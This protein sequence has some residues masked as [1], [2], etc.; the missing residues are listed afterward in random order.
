LLRHQAKRTTLALSQDLEDAGE[1]DRRPF[2]PDVLRTL[3]GDQ[4]RLRAAHVGTKQ[5]GFK[6]RLS[7]R[8]VRLFGGSCCASVSGCVLYRGARWNLSKK[9]FL[10]LKRK[11]KNKAKKQKEKTRKQKKRKPKAEKEK[12]EKKKTKKWSMVECTVG[13]RKNRLCVWR[14]VLAAVRA[15]EANRE[16]AGV[17]RR[18]ADR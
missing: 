11:Q 4:G 8:I 5:K 7:I 16:L 18:S 10:F 15:V 14:S 1:H 13:R 9:V 3:G 6:A 12:G 2:G 17:A